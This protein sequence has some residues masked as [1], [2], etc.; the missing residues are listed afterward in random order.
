VKVIEQE[1]AQAV[2]DNEHLH[3]RE[4]AAASST[5]SLPTGGPDAA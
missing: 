2:K 3:R 4:A 1:N 5:G